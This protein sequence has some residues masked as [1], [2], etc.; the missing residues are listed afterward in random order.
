MGHPNYH[1]S[2][3]SVML[4]KINLL[5][6]KPDERAKKGLMLAFQ[7]PMSVPGVTLSNFLRTAFAQIY[8]KNSLSMVEFHNLIRLEA[9]RLELDATFL[10]RA[11]NDGFSGGEKK[12]AEMLQLLV[13]KPK[14]AIF[15]EIDTG[16]D[17]D[18][19]KTVASGINILKNQGVGILLIT[20]YQRILN[21]VQ[22]ERVHVMMQGKF[23]KEGGSELA[24]LLEEKGYAAI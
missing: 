15:D 9:K 5:N 4:G 6:L 24:T 11:I 17:I 14:I 19:L 22:P 23:I 2:Q 21:Y 7:N 1:V 8:G 16:L 3:G 18:A 10:R 13:L 20:H 12:K